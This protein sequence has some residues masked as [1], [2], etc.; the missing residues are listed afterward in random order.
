MEEESPKGSDFLLICLVRD[1]APIIPLPEVGRICHVSFR[2]IVNGEVN[3]HVCSS[4]TAR[5]HGETWTSE[6]ERLSIRNLIL[7][8]T[9]CIK[10]SNGLTSLNICFHFC[11]MWTLHASFRRWLFVGLCRSLDSHL[12]LSSLFAVCHYR[13][14]AIHRPLFV[15][16]ALDKAEH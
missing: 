8:L 12:D 16:P 10:V 7:A 15:N 13:M 2:L 9:T 11:H 5:F 3:D 14:E 6:S 4:P 1:R